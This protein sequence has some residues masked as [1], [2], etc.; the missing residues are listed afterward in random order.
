MRGGNSKNLISAEDRGELIW[1]ERAAL[2]MQRANRGNETLTPG[3][4]AERNLKRIS[5]TSGGLKT[6][7]RMSY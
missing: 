1:S 3:E 6:P 5:T 7:R 4:V 2:A